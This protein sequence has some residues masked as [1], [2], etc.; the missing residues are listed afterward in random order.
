M[1]LSPLFPKK[2]KGKKG[3]EM[4]IKR[5]L[6]AK[7]LQASKKQDLYTRFSKSFLDC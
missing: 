2:E 6:A 4:K 7:K 3:V 1:E 5:A